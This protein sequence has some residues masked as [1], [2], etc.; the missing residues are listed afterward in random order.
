MQVSGLIIIGMGVESLVLC[1]V[2][3]L[4]TSRTLSLT[5]SL[6]AEQG[7]VHTQPMRKDKSPPCPHWGH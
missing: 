3:S 6:T 5:E 2:P 7:G 1:P 4:P